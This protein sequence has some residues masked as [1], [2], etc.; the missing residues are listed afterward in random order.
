MK[1]IYC[2]IA[3]AQNKMEH[4]I[5]ERK[6][7]TNKEIKFFGT[8]TSLDDQLTKRNVTIKTDSPKFIR[9]QSFN[10]F[11]PRKSRHKRFGRGLSMNSIVDDANSKSE[12]SMR[13]KNDNYNMFNIVTKSLTTEKLCNIQQANIGCRSLHASK[14]DMVDENDGDS[15]ADDAVAGGGSDGDKLISISE[16]SMGGRSS[17]QQLLRTSTIKTNRISRLGL[18][19]FRKRSASCDGYDSDSIKRYFH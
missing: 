7:M 11:S 4:S 14:L 1:T 19:Q 8:S 6:P 12:C 18:H 16:E 13:D 9:A 5:N 10:M 17:R 15:S 2:G 3:K